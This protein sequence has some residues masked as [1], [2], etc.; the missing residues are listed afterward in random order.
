MQDR[1]EVY[2]SRS[3][4]SSQL[5]SML[6]AFQKHLT[7][8]QQWRTDLINV[9]HE[10]YKTDINYD[11]TEFS[12]PN[13]TK[14]GLQERADVFAR[15]ILRC[16]NYKEMLDRH[17]RITDRHRETFEWIFYENTPE[18]IADVS[19]DSFSQW[20]KNPSQL[21][22]ITGK[23]GAGKSTLMKF[24]HDDPFIFCERFRFYVIRDR[25]SEERFR[26]V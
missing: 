2:S 21:Y 7:G 4:V 22:W 19:W 20:L 12:Q 25:R 8:D 26:N 23:A 24:L 10:K 3:D 17:D 15:H 18:H 14:Y 5:D 11:A 9:I 16:L 1:E 13:I 6:T